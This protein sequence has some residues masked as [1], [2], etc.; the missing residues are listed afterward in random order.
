V[1][2]GAD[3]TIFTSRKERIIASTETSEKAGARITILWNVDMA[4]H[5]LLAIIDSMWAK[6]Q[7]ER[8]KIRT[9]IANLNWI[10][11]DL[12]GRGFDG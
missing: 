10:K 12:F 5:P 2:G 6:V 3:R 8:V 9:V 11:P 7:T 1:L 4:A